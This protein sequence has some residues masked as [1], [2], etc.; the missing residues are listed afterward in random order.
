MVVAVDSSEGMITESERHSIESV[1]G[2]ARGRYPVVVTH[3]PPAKME[4]GSRGW[5]VGFLERA[6]VSLV[7]VGH[8]HRNHSYVIGKTE[9]HEIRCL[10][11][12]KAIGG[13]SDLTVFHLDGGHWQRSDISFPLGSA[14]TWSDNEKNAFARLLGISCTDDPLGGLDFATTAGVRYVELRDNAADV[15]RILLRRKLAAWRH[16]G[17]AYLSWHVPN[18]RWDTERAELVC[19]DQWQASLELALSLG[20]QALTVHT[21]SVPVELMDS[22][23][24]R[25]CNILETYSED[26]SPAARQG[27]VIGIENSHMYAG[28]C[29][30]PSRRFGCLPDECYQWIV[31]LRDRLGDDCVGLLLDVGHARNNP[32]FS[33][34]ITLGQWYALL[35]GEAVGLHLHQVVE[36]SCGM[37]N[38]EPIYDA[39]APLISCSSLLWAWKT[40]QLN[41]C[42]MFL[43]VRGG[44]SAWSESLRAMREG[45]GLASSRHV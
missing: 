2:V 41:H 1:V 19:R 12:D 30:G 18:I 26:L 25:W 15:P 36:T 22:G 20:A 39:F 11:P 3:F 6:R 44:I 24:A 31:A 42:P 43:E 16:T 45:A 21:P 35:G 37:Q 29:S 9:V 40:G 7:L 34:R 27:I 14:D 10:D 4:F 8:L 38:H 32:P 23:S 17:G 33:N 13:T 5:F 28:E